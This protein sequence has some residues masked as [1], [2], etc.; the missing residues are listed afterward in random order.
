MLEE[1]RQFYNEHHEEWISSHRGEVALV[2]G[3]ELI[4]FFEDESEALAEGGRKFRGENFLVRR[5]DCTNRQE[6]RIPALS[7]RLLR[8][9]D[10]S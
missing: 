8:S 6:A 10:Q 7:L 1:E 4:G 5:V 2:K 9:S 3:R